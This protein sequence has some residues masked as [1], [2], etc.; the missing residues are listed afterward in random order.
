MNI[1]K[2]SETVLKRSVLNQIEH[3]RKEVLVGPA[4]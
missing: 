1:G 4:V 3:R 2:I